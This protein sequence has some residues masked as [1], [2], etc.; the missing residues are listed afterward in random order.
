MFVEKQ[1]RVG[2]PFVYICIIPAHNAIPVILINTPRRAIP[3][4]LL[5]RFSLCVGTVD[6]KRGSFTQQ[7]VIQNWRTYQTYTKWRR[8]GVT[9]TI[10]TA[11]SLIPYP[12]YL[13][14]LFY[15]FPSIFVCVYR[16]SV[17]SKL[18]ETMS[19][20]GGVESIQGPSAQ[21]QNFHKK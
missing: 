19:R 6:A 5:S 13:I 16:F 1:I 11:S 14:F 15:S 12:F 2:Y 8:E 17:H 3:L 10:T 7:I 9:M 18:V 20:D 4:C 21:C